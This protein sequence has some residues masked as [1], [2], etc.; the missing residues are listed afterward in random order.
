MLAVEEIAPTRRRDMAGSQDPSD[1]PVAVNVVPLVDI[2]FCL[3]VFFMCS[4]KFKQ[5]EGKFETWLPKSEGPPSDPE[6]PILLPSEIRVA[7]LWDEATQ[8]VSR[9]LGTRPFPQ[10]EELGKALGE[11]RS[12]WASKGRPDVPMTID[13]DVRVPW[14]EVATVVDLATARDIAKIQFA[15]GAAPSPRARAR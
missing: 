11:A 14:Q 3:C 4:F 7:L 13:A 10:D 12:A 6:Q 15:L 1:N 8:T 9:K 5:L 2:I